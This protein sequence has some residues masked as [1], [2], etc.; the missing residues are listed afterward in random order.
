VF[1]LRLHWFAAVATLQAA[2]QGMPPAIFRTAWAIGASS[3][4]RLRPSPIARAMTVPMQ[5]P[6]RCGSRGMETG[7]GCG[8]HDV[9]RRAYRPA[10]AKRVKGSRTRTWSVH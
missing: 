8:Q 2:R 6:S 7:A 10:M 1:P 5:T 9:V 4:R 3:K